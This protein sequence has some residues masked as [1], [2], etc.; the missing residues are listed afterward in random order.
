V[1]LFNLKHALSSWQSGVQMKRHSTD[2]LE[3]REHV[4]RNLTSLDRDRSPF[5]AAPAAEK[6]GKKTE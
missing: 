2:H 5:L 6:G 1:C 3:T 4:L